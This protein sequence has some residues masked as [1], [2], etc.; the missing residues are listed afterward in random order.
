MTLT[1]Q[2]ILSWYNS[3]TNLKDSLK[4]KLYKVEEICNVL[5]ISLLKK[6]T[7]IVEIMEFEILSRLGKCKTN[8]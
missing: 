5:N 8:K 2:K 4:T 6:K 3:E 7:L 1:E